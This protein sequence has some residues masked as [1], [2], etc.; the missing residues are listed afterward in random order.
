MVKILILKI[1][2]LSPGKPCSNS[3]NWYTEASSKTLAIKKCTCGEIGGDD[4]GLTS[5]PD[6]Y[7]EIFRVNIRNGCAIVENVEVKFPSP[8]FLT[9]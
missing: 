2:I 9:R 3:G 4:K 7:P 6:T 8:G 5:K 1:I